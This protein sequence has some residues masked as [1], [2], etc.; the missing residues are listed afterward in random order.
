[1]FVIS[2]A[3]RDPLFLQIIVGDI[4]LSANWRIVRNDNDSMKILYWLI[5][6]GIFIAL[7]MAVWAGKQ[8]VDCTEIAKDELDGL[9][10]RS[11]TASQPDP[12]FCT[13][14]EALFASWQ[15]CLAESE[16]AKQ[17]YFSPV[18]QLLN[19]YTDQS[20]QT[21]WQKHLQVCPL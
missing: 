2:S 6:L 17:S 20:L 19:S 4:S 21:R 18:L 11:I 13:K 9:N 15:T 12:N 5:A 10:I 3:A 1:M 14:E 8:Y 7:I 16:L